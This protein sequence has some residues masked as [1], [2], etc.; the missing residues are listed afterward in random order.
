MIETTSLHTASLTVPVSGDP[1][2]QITVA[3]DP[4]AHT[5]T[6]SVR[7]MVSEQDA[8]QKIRQ[9]LAAAKDASLSQ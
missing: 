1:A 7:S 2:D 8:R 4:G 6:F 9:F 5:L 3:Y